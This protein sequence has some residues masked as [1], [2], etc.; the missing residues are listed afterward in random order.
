VAEDAATTPATAGRIAQT[1]RDEMIFRVLVAATLLFST[2]NYSV[3]Q[4]PNDAKLA[5]ARAHMYCVRDNVAK[6]DDGKMDPNHL[7]EIIMPLCHSLHEA[8]EQAIQP[9][10]WNATSPNKAHEVEFTH[11]LAAVLWARD[12]LRH[13]Q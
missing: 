1:G 7:A 8:S 3:A 6:F 12:N 2:T 11:T 9:Q 10:E 5:A 13:S 4:S